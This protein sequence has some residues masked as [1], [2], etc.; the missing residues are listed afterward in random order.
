MTPSSVIAVIQ[1]IL[2]LTVVIVN[3]VVKKR[4]DRRTAQRSLEAVQTVGAAA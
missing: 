1:A 2:V 3:Q 4:M